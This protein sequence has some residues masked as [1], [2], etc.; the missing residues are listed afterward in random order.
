MT[1]YATRALID[2]IAYSGHDPAEDPAWTTT[3]A[4][5]QSTYG[6]WCRHMCGIACLRMVLLHRDGQAPKPFQL[7][8][9]ARRYGAYAKQDDGTIKGLIYAPFAEYARDTYDLPVTVHGTLEMGE[10]V[11][12]LDAGRMVMASVSKEIRRPEIDPERRGGHLVLAIGRHK[13]QIAFRNPSGHTP[14]ARE[15]ALPTHRFAEFFGSRGL[16]LDLSRPQYHSP[17]HA[18]A[19]TSDPSTGPVASTQTT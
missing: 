1:Q 8:A 19:V 17:P 18:A 10:L 15:A 4:P 14:Q 5:S 3:G 11:D 6:R 16:S 2:R 9:G 12:L 7:L 13:D